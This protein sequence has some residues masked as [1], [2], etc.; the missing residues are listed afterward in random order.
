MNR[1]VITNERAVLFRNTDMVLMNLLP[2]FEGRRTWLKGGGLSFAASRHNIE[3]CHSAFPGLTI[4]D[5]REKEE[6]PST[7][8][9]YKPKVPD[10]DHQA[11][12]KEKARAKRHFALFMIPG[13][14]KSKVI[15][16]RAGELWSAGKI[17]AVLIV[18]KK[19]P[20][21]QLVDFHIPANFNGEWDGRYWPVKQLPPAILYPT[22][23][24]L[25]FFTINVDAIKTA[26][27]HTAARQF[28][29][30]HR[31]NV[32]MVMDESHLIKNAR[33]KRW[34]AAD[35]LGR[36]CRFRMLSTGTPLA[37]DLTDEWAQ[38]KWLDENILGI[39]YAVA[40]RAE[41]CVMGGFE[42]RQVIAH[43]NLERF[44]ARIDPYSFRVS[45]EELKLPPKLHDV[46]KFDL[47]PEQRNAFQSMKKELLAKIDSGE[48][49]SAANAA[50]ASLRLQQIANG[51]IV[52]D[53]K[54]IVHLFPEPRD[55]PRIAAML[56]YLEALE[57][58]KAIIWARFQEDIRIIEKV[59]GDDCVSYYG[60]TK[61][62]DRQASL[63]AFL[64][65]KARWFVSNPS[66]GG[67]G[68]DGLQ[69]VCDAALYYSNS[70]N[71]IDR[72]QS[73]DRLHRI[74]TKGSVNYT[75][76]IAIGSTDAKILRSLQRKEM[77]SELSLSDIR[78]WLES[79]DEVDV[80][81]V[82]TSNAEE[83]ER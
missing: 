10:F 39:R 13:S 7:K 14:G 79:D 28:I 41:Y 42:F 56:E 73:E 48:I 67:T 30:A 53:D 82:I 52:D 24:R 38:L 16:D 75:D 26:R 4:E 3:L 40:F 44:K 6:A 21:R 50:V 8:S 25:A 43:K 60:E 27:G 12:A 54:R 59:L 74:G 71:S 36:R 9:R 37:K 33:S 58:R 69:S 15:I 35:D 77:L 64:K 78:L 32:L 51:F 20:H 34:R 23:K 76:L 2:R 49:T 83:W 66:V 63:D 57:D 17:T 5:Q 1:L 31:G 72:W 22:K 61:A 65:G 11:R 80:A 46:W 18:S 68:L 70:D 29:I 19:G 47:T 55:N 62:K 81:S 45:K